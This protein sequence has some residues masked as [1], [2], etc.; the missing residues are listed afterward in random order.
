[1]NTVCQNKANLNISLIFTKA[2]NYET[3]PFKYS[4]INIFSA[5]AP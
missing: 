2:G 5:V 4:K 3:K 1:M